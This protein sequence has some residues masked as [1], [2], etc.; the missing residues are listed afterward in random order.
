MKYCDLTIKSDTA[1]HSICN[2]SHVWIYR[3][4]NLAG[5]QTVQ[6]LLTSLGA[7]YTYG[8]VHPALPHWA[9][10]LHF[11]PLKFHKKNCTLGVQNQV[12]DFHLASSLL[13]P[14]CFFVSIYGG[15]LLRASSG[16]K[17]RTE[18][19]PC[20][21]GETGEQCGGSCGAAS[22]SPL[23]HHFHSNLL[24]KQPHT[25]VLQ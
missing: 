7:A 13:S 15:N 10:N 24:L 14:N 9:V 4:L 8:R 16:E 25:L 12:W 2:S 21:C 22:N 19:N 11:W 5:R 1:Q 6:L 17:L 3:I 23:L 20:S 18:L